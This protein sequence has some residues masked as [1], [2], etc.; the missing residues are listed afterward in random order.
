MNLY[1]KYFHFF[2]TSYIKENPGFLAKCGWIIDQ[3][4]KKFIPFTVEFNIPD[5]IEYSRMK[6]DWFNGL[7]QSKFWNK[8]ISGKYFES[9]CAEKN[10]FYD[11]FDMLLKNPCMLMIFSYSIHGIL[12][13]YI[14]GYNNQKLPTEII[15]NDDSKIFSLC[16]HGKNPAV[17]KVAANLLANFFTISPGKWAT[18][19]RN[20]HISSTSLL[21]RKFDGLFCYKSVP[22]IVTSKN[23]CFTRT[24]SIV[25]KLHKKREDSWFHC[26][27]VYIS[28]SPI[29]AD[30]IVNCCSDSMIGK[31]NGREDNLLAEIH[32]QFCCLV[33][34]FIYYLTKISERGYHSQGAPNTKLLQNENDYFYITGNLRELVSKINF[35]EEWMDTHLPNV[36]LYS[37]MECFCYYLESTP[38]SEYADQLRKAS[39]IC[40]L[41]DKQTKVKEQ[42]KQEI[43]YM[44]LLYRFVKLNLTPEN[45]SWIWEGREPRDKKEECYYFHP[46]DGFDMFLKALHKNSIQAI[47]KS[48]FLEL[49]KFHDILKM[50]KSERSNTWQ[51]ENIKGERKYVLVFLK[52]KLDSF[53]E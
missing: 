48:E 36:L 44:N 5:K 11:L 21:R 22:I 23:N 19:Q 10:N 39:E 51:R 46:G 8:G 24:S 33:Y 18:V 25:K 3:N 6:K 16:I 9:I 15:P 41:P 42:P 52:E 40:F 45:G 20:Y 34:C 7:L 26:Y 30:E 4:I 37:T 13:N 38:L 12:W 27:P 28:T 2:I 47:G 43:N 50:P 53:A 49:L 14:R 29:M 17:S 32:D 31:L 1:K 35:T